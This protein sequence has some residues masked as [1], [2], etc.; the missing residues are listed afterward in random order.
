[1]P[2]K[3]LPDQVIRHKKTGKPVLVVHVYRN[4]TIV[5][6]LEDPN[7]P[8]KIM[9]ILIRDYGDWF[10]DEKMTCDIT[11]LYGSY[12]DDYKFKWKARK[13]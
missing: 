4:A 13:R 8:T 11:K 2:Q 1:M 9:T 5:A 12:Y 10:P 6:D 3:Y 7:S